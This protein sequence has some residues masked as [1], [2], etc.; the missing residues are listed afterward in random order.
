MWIDHILTTGTSLP[1]S[2]PEGPVCSIFIADQEDISGVKQTDG[3]TVESTIDSVRRSIR[4]LGTEQ[5]GMALYEDFGIKLAAGEQV[6]RGSMVVLSSQ[7]PVQ[8]D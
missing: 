8:S 1:H 7:A 3:V 2:L 5:D 4:Q 6:G